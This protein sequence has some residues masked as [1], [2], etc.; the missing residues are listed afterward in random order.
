MHLRDESVQSTGAGDQ[1][2]GFHPGFFPHWLSRHGHFGYH[3]CKHK[4]RIM[5]ASCGS[6]GKES[7][8]NVGD[9]C[10]IPELGRAT[11]EGKGYPLQY[12][13]LEKSMDCIVHDITK[14]WT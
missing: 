6:A 14:S 1:T 12:F 9:L 10:S 7:A 4:I 2:P 8:S 11:G 13:G 3:P 5:G